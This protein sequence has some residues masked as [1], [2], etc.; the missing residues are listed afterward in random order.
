MSSPS[1][2]TNTVPVVASK[3]VNYDNMTDEEFSLVYT[4]GIWGWCDHTS[5]IQYL[6]GKVIG[7]VTVDPYNQIPD[8]IDCDK[9]RAMVKERWEDHPMRNN[10]EQPERLCEFKHILHTTYTNEE[11]HAAIFGKEEL[12]QQQLNEEQTVR[13]EAVTSVAIS[14]SA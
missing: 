5:I 9:L 2:T 12:Q 10:G 8:F 7:I 13:S 1:T 3:L 11:V 6:K 4:T 14:A